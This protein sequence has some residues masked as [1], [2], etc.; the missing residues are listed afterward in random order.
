M[1]STTSSRWA[2]S[3]VRSNP[4]DF[5]FSVSSS[6]CSSSNATNTPG[7]PILHRAMDEEFHGHERLAAGPAAPQ[8]SVGRPVGKPDPVIS[9]IPSMSGAAL[10]QGC[11]GESILSGITDRRQRYE[12]L[13][14]RSIQ[15]A[16][17]RIELQGG[18]KHVTCC[19][20]GSTEKKPS[21]RADADV[22][23]GLH[24]FIDAEFQSTLNAAASW[25]ASRGRPSFAERLILR[26][27]APYRTHVI[28]AS[29]HLSVRRIR[30]HSARAAR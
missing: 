19:K 28:A 13:A 15:I 22:A 24:A 17:A 25:D 27:A 12:L 10:L 18:A 2:I 14:R 3:S 30:R 23:N 8:I 16:A 26:P 4:S 11:A 29:G 7:C 6:G 21:G 5:T 20:L 9:S 1:N